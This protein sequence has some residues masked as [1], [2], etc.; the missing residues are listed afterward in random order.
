MHEM[1]VSCVMID[2][3]YQR[4]TSYIQIIERRHF[5]RIAKLATDSLYG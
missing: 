3:V 1:H 2:V 5:G 4:L